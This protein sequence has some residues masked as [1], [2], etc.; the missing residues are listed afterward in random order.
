MQEALADWERFLRERDKLPDLIQCA[1]MHEQFEAIH[2]FLDG[3]G[4]VGRLLITLFLN[5]RGR[6]SQPLLYLSAYIE[7]HRQDYYALLQR[8]RTDGDW[9]GWLRF[10][11]TG[12]TET[13]GEAVRHAGRLMDLREKFRA[14]LRDK[15]K[16]L[17]LLDQLFINPYMTVARAE[18]ILKVSNPTA[19]QAVTLLQKNGMLEEISGRAWGRLYLAKPILRAIENPPKPK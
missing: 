10:F 7:A 9:I 3:N 13:A 1:L 12:V 6:L 2:P 14:R 16:A 18:R 17:A 4:R 11:I 5:E 15:P 8:V 19:R